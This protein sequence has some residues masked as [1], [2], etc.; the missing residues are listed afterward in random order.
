MEVCLNGAQLVVAKP[1]VRESSTEGIYFFVWL[2][3]RWIGSK[4]CSMQVYPE[5][6]RFNKVPVD[7]GC[8]VWVSSVWVM[9]VCM[10]VCAQMQVEFEWSK[11]GES[12]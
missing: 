9:C 2:D 11:Q 6:M 4:P 5:D 1:L 8:C 12:C 10:C 3:F 7:M